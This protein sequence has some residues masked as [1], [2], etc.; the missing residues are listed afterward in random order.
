M[1]CSDLGEGLV[2]RECAPTHGKVRT[3]HPGAAVG[4]CVLVATASWAVGGI[5]GVG[6]AAPERDRVNRPRALSL[7]P[8]GAWACVYTP[9]SRRLRIA[10]MEEQQVSVHIP[11]PPGFSINSQHHCLSS[12]RL[13]C[14]PKGLSGSICTPLGQLQALGPPG[15]PLA[16]PWPGD[17]SRVLW[18]SGV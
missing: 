18:G 15:R 7:R 2:P 16:L 11:P 3:L 6:K 1:C 8:Q 13:T 14:L 9:L 12:H 17:P 5:G 4:S 10:Q